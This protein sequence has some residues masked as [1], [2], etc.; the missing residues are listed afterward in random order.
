M[1][2]ALASGLLCLLLIRAKDFVHQGGPQ[3]G[4]G[5]GEGQ[6]SSSLTPTA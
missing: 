1:V 2:I 6:P 4:E 3:G 5:S